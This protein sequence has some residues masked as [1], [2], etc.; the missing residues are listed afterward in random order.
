MAE[1]SPDWIRIL[2]E[3]VKSVGYCIQY[4][5]GRQKKVKDDILN[6]SSRQ[7]ANIT[8]DSIQGGDMNNNPRAPY[9]N[10]CQIVIEKAE[11]AFLISAPTTKTL[12]SIQEEDNRAIIAALTDRNQQKPTLGCHSLTSGYEEEVALKR[13]GKRQ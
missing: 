6:Y 7:E 12:N 11:N 2:L 10:Q 13:N 1:I 8:I 9:V 4:M 3:T 5:F